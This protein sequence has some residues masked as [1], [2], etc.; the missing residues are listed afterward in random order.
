MSNIYIAYNHS[1]Q[2]IA[3]FIGKDKKD[4]EIA[5]AGMKEPI[6]HIEEID[7][8]STDITSQNIIFLLTSTSMNSRDFSHRIGG[9]DF[10]EWK[11]GI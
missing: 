9:V 8:N 7:P 6:K 3:I 5:L 10:R 2:P 1:N 4:I 11:R